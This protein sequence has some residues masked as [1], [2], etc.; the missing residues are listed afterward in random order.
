MKELFISECTEYEEGWGSK[1]DGFL[2]SESI[3]VM[4][5]EIKRINDLDTYAY[6]LRFTEPQKIFCEKKTYDLIVEK[7][8]GKGFSHY[9][10]NGLKGLE[11]YKKL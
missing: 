7:F 1:P 8:E 6:F 4:E 10:N 11:L 5:A 3:D 2:I 9:S